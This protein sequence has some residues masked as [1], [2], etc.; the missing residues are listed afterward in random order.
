MI[1]SENIMTIFNT[2]I[3]FFSP[4]KAVEAYARAVPDRLKG[5]ILLGSSMPSS[6]G[7]PLAFPLPVLT[8]V[9]ELDGVTKITSIAY[10]LQ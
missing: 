8:L 10:A 7:G 3:L 2:V 1:L 6:Q 4:G 9:G 5:L